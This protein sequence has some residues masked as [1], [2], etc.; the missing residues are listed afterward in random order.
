VSEHSYEIAIMHTVLDSMTGVTAPILGSGPISSRGRLVG[1]MDKSLSRDKIQQTGQ[2]ML[3]GDGV[4]IIK[5]G[6][7]QLDIVKARQR[8]RQLIE[9]SNHHPA[10]LNKSSLRDKV[11][12]LMNRLTAIIN[13]SPRVSLA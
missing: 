1:R 3:E 8:V 11:F 4:L 6:A 12:D 9:M 7:L 10:A 2:R 5:D 13:G